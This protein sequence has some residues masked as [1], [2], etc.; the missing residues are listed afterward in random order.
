MKEALLEV[1][2][3]PQRESECSARPSV[4]PLFTE[5]PLRAKRLTRCVS[6]PRLLLDERLVTRMI[7][8]TPFHMKMRLRF[9]LGAGLP[10][11]G[12]CGGTWGLDGL[13]ETQQ[14]TLPSRKSCSAPEMLAAGSCSCVATSLI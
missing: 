9:L 7:A 12:W 5:G 8:F 2:V 1:P 6:G 11:Q 10:Y 13:C 3:H 4:L 14:P